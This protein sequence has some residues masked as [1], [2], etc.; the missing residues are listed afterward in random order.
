MRYLC[1]LLSLFSTSAL[2]V[3]WAWQL[4]SATV[5]ESVVTIKKANG[6]LTRYP[7]QC[8]LTDALNENAQQSSTIQI[9]VPN[10]HPKGLLILSCHQGEHAQ[11]L[12]IIDPFK[13]KVVYKRNGRYFVDWRL[14]D[15]KL[16]IEY[17]RPCENTQDNACLD[18]N[19]D[20]MTTADTWP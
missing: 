19:S 13:N 2:A 20:L 4:E 12:S 11:I 5:F 16:V 14:E 7:F 17:D 18:D 3:D 10:S 1:L 15:G 6:Y 8:D 9:V